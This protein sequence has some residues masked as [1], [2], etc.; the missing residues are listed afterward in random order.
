MLDN[1][2]V[3]TVVFRHDSA[4]IKCKHGMDYIQAWNRKIIFSI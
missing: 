3:K 1:F 2:H 4:Y